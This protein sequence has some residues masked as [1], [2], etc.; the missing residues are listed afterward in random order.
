LRNVA[1]Q[2][3]LTK[4]L[5]GSRRAPAQVVLGSAVALVVASCGADTAPPTPSTGGKGGTTAGGTGGAPGGAA[6][7]A[8]TL[9][10]GAG[11][12]GGTGA[13]TGGVPGGTGG[14]GSGGGGTVAPACAAT[15]GV[16]T[17]NLTVNR[18]DIGARAI[19]PVPQGTIRIAADPMTGALLVATQGGDISSLDPATG[20]M[21]DAGQGFPGGEIRG[22][23]FGPDG[24]LYVLTVT[25][26]PI[27]ATIHKGVPSGGSRTWSTLASTEGFNGPAGNLSNYGHNY[28]NLVVDANN[29]YVYFAS[30]SRTEHGEDNNGREAALSSA[31]LR[32]PVTS[33]DLTLP[34][35]EGGLTQYL[36]AD[37][38]RNA[39]SINFNHLGELFAVDNGP[40]IDFPD[41]V[42]FVEQ[43]KHYGFPWRFGSE[44]NPVLDPAY[45]GDGDARLH[46]QLQAVQQGTYTY[47]SGFAPKPAG[48]T[49]TDPIKNNGPDGD[50][51]IVGPQGTV[52]DASEAQAALYGI[53]AHRSPTGL[54]FDSEGALCGDYYQ[55]GFFVNYG[56]VQDFMG[57]IGLDLMMMQL[58]KVG[59]AYEMT[60]TQLITGFADFPIDAAIV[61]NK[62][63]V[64]EYN[65][66]NAYEITLPV[67]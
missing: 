57:D 47:D 21:A 9:P 29:E 2:P 16:V 24:T 15:T 52:M 42:N 49:F 62:I 18:T 63:Y 8:G 45:T 27:S 31:I 51:V 41:E 54:V 1:S 13:G 19:G 20:Q 65:G 7:T 33:A 26:G 12:A 22:M 36:F 39:F 38:L 37:G 14:G 35:N 30:G 25:T 60:L 58:T 11:G 6:G 56:A 50:K 61:G 53:T 32:V 10:G 23:K 5:G 46:D 48:V 28:S 4:I 64:V 59:A 66:G 3:W 17:A 43:G 67:P 40:D 55:A 44:D 34:N